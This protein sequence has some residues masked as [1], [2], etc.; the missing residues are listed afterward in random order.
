MASDLLRY[1][2]LLCNH[3]TEFNEP[4]HESRSRLP[5]PSLCFVGQ[6]E[7]QDGRLWLNEVSSTSLQSLNEIQRNFTWSKISTSSTK[8]GH[9]DLW[10]SKTFWTSTFNHWTEFDETW[11]EIRSQ[12]IL[13]KVC[14]FSGWSE[15]QDY[16]SGLWLADTFSI[17]PLQPLTRRGLQDLNVL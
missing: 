14:I 16:R 6:S 15:N 9:P 3:W 13:Y 1:S 12:Y 17:F 7:N 4:W 10:L 8:D 11:Q 5:V 2:R